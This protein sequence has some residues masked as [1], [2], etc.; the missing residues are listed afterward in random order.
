MSAVTETAEETRVADLGPAM[1]KLT[2]KQ[3]KFVLALFEA[4]RSHGEGTFAAEMAGY[5][6]KSRDVLGV[7]ASQLKADPKIQAAIAETSRLY[8]TA[9]GPAAVRS[10][11]RVLNNPK[12]RDH[13]RVLGIVFDRVS[14]VQSTALVKVEHEAAPSMRAT[15]EVLERIMQL[16]ARAK[17]PPMIDVTPTPEKA[18]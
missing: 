8:L 18:L 2:P 13:G 7:I 1:L 11:R 4:P 5:Q 17:V 10:A 3:R 6:A 9:L 16:A 14:P 12:H 15:A